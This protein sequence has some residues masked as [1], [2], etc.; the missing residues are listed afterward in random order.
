[1]NVIL[2]YPAGLLLAGFLGDR[3]K[4]RG[5]ILL[6][7]VICCLLSRGI[8]HMQYQLGIGLAETDDVL[9][10]SLGGVIGAMSSRMAAAYKYGNQK[11]SRA[12]PCFL[13]TYRVLYLLLAVKG[14]GIA[15]VKLDFLT[16]GHFEWN[17]QSRWVIEKCGFQNIKT[18][19]FET[20]YGTIQNSSEYILCRGDW[21]KNH[22]DT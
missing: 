21:R 2:F 15:V 4:R 12:L 16:V 13:F 10:N 6:I 5:K 1:M 18:I 20:R 8:E 17:D 11:E 9:H 22:A 3:W 7:L 19:K 14:Y